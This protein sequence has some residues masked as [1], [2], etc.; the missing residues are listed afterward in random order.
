MV[1][2]F[3]SVSGQESGKKVKSLPVKTLAVDLEHVCGFGLIAVAAFQDNI[4]DLLCC[5]IK[6]KII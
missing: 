2:G 1:R 3:E 5:R 4:F 6:G